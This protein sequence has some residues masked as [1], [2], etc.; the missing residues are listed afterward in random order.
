MEQYVG[1]VSNADQIKQTLTDT[2]KKLETSQIIVA[3]NTDSVKV[4]QLWKSWSVKQKL[5]WFF[6]NKL[7]VLKESSNQI[8]KAIDR[9]N[10][11]R[12]QTEEFD[13]YFDYMEYPE[14]LQT[15]PK[16]I[17]VTHI[18][19]KPNV[20]MEYIQLDLTISGGDQL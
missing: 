10:A 11:L 16:Q 17:M 8:R 14:H 15:D 6:H 20:G 7:P 19:L 2:L 3:H 1:T 5:K 4:E 12:F 13:G 9:Y 18:N